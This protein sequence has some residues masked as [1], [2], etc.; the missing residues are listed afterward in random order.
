[1]KQPIAYDDAV[2]LLDADHKAV[3]KWF[4]DHAALREDAALAADKYA[5]SP[6]ICQALALHAQIE[7]ATDVLFKITSTN[8][9]FVQREKGW[10][11]VV[12]KPGS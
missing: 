3:K 8:A 4:M 9:S 2:D 12:L 10:T 1:M 11:K 6:R 5:L 7:R